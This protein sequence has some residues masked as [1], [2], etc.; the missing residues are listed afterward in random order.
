MSRM[1]ARFCTAPNSWLSL[2]NQQIEIKSWVSSEVVNRNL[3][4]QGGRVNLGVPIH[5][6]HYILIIFLVN[7]SFWCSLN[8]SSRTAW[9]SLKRGV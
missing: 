8:H 4:W 5:H 3:G 7:E 2:E 9:G 6:F 1:R